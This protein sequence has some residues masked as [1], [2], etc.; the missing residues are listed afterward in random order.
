MAHDEWRRS[1]EVESAQPVP[2]ALRRGDQ[3][4]ILSEFF[5]SI[6]PL[7]KFKLRHPECLSPNLHS[8]TCALSRSTLEK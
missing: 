5:N 7:L 2:Q 8:C 4:T 3:N 6:A 1:D